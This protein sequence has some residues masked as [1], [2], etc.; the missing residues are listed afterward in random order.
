LTIVKGKYIIGILFTGEHKRGG[1]GVCELLGMSANVPTDICFSFTGLIQRSGVTG[2]HRDGWGI[3]F[4]EGKG[5]RAFKDSGAGSES[6]IAGLVKDYPI[7][8]KIVVSHIRKAN[9]GKVCLE[10]TH[11]FTRVMDGRYWTAA[12]NGQL[13]GVKEKKLTFYHPVG[14]TDSEHAYCWLLDQIHKKFKNK[15]PPLSEYQRYIKQLCLKL[16]QLGIFNFLLSDSVFLY[17]FCSTKLFWITRLAPFGEAKLK[18]VDM[19][20]DFKKETSPDDIVTVVAS[21]PLTV[22]ETWQKMEEGSLAIFKEG[23]LKKIL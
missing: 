22:N 2:P 6:K 8:S 20:I 7:K 11:P 10:N 18:D 3:I 5:V 19:I 12:H 21:Q 4:Y 15:K 16:S 1:D 14:T 9:R 23:Q 13:K 17:A